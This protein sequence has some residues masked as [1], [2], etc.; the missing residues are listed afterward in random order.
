MNEIH[1]SQDMEIIFEKVQLF[2]VSNLLLTAL[3]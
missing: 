3:L 2:S 1:N